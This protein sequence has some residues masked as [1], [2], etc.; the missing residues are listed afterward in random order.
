LA[1]VKRYGDGREAPL[2]FDLLRSIILR[3]R[4][5]ADILRYSHKNLLVA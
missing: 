2:R 3:K 1:G 4:R 5:R